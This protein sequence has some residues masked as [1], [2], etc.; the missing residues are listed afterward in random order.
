M[1][2]EELKSELS[3]IL[4]AEEQSPP[5]WGQVEERSLRTI[6]RLATEPRPDYPHEVV[7]HYLDD[8]D[9]RQTSARYGQHQRKRLKRWLEDN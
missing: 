8:L 6:G 7:Y 3:A 1:T 9:V 5:D 2:L 4:A